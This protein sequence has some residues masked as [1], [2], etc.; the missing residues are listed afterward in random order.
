MPTDTGLLEAALLG[1][2]A[3]LAQIQEQIAGLQ[4][5]IGRKVQPNSHAAAVPPARPRPRISVAG[6]KRIAEAQ[7]KRWQEYYRTHGKGKETPAKAARA[8]A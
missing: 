6:R 8:G 5:Q 1:Y 7:R 2:K 4:R 3:Q